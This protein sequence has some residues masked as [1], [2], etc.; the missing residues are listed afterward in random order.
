MVQHRLG[1]LEAPGVLVAPSVPEVLQGR[2]RR[3]CRCRRPEERW[4]QLLTGDAWNTLQCEMAR[5]KMMLGA[6]ALAGPRTV[7]AAEP[8][9][10]FEVLNVSDP[11]TRE[12]A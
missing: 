9:I 10:R 8:G 5:E 1:V 2:R 6:L 3:G 4:R 11:Y 12:S 7:V